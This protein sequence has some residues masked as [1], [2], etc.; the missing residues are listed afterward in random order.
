MIDPTQRESFERDG[1][2]L[3]PGLIDEHWLQRLRA[4]IERDIARPGPCYHGYEIEGGGRFHGNMRNWEVD[5]DFRDYCQ[6]SLLP[7][8]AAALL[9][10]DE[11]RLYYD[12]LF[13]KEPGTNA[14]TRWHNDQP[15]WPV[16]GWPI[17]SFWLALD[18]VTKESGALEFVQGSHRWGKW[19]QPE[20]FAP[21]GSSYE[22]NPDYVEIPDIGAERDRHGFLTWDMQPGDVIAFHALTVHG[23]P[24][25]RSAGRRRGY[26]VRYCG[27]G[28]TYYG[29]PGTSPLLI[30]DALAD[31]APL[32]GRRYPVV[33]PA[34][35]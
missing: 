29:G 28:M 31:G 30:D 33:W 35:R 16:R 12:Q 8:A 19:F 7:E 9:D 20:P 21:G 15:Y 10:V 11:V 25:N 34:R 32:E 13:V 2:L 22:R 27:P 3:L 17:L 18:P 14:P 24:P 1:A 5:P 6:R 23:G 26:T 4:A